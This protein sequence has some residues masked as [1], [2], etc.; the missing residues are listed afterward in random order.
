LRYSLARVGRIEDVVTP[1]YDVISPAEQER[2]YAASPYNIV[3]LELNKAQAGDNDHDNPARRAAAELSRWRAEGV[4]ARD[5]EP[6]FYL[7]ETDYAAQ[8]QRYCRRGFIGV[9][10]AEEFGGMVRRHE[11]TFS[12]VKADRLRLIQECR[13][14]LSPVFGLYDDAAD[15]AIQALA[16]HATGAPE[17]SFD[18]Q[19]GCTH[20][21]WRVSN[22]AALR[23]ATEVLGRSV[24]VVADGHHRYETA[25]L[26]GQQMRARYPEAPPRAP[27]NYVMMYLCNSL[28]PGLTVLPAHRLV[29]APA[30]F[31]LPEFE[32]SAAAFFEVERL[33]QAGGREAFLAALTAR[34]AAGRSAIGLY[35][36]AGEPYR[37]LTLKDGVM[38]R[39]MDGPAGDS[40][41][42]P[43][44]RL[45][46][47]VF[48]RIVL[49]RL[50]GLPGDE[51]EKLIQY[52]SDS[53]QA[54]ETA[55]A[56]GRL[57]FLLN[58]TKV[59]QVQ[60]VAAQ[61]LTMPRKSTYFCPKVMSG[62]A[63]HPLD[64]PPDPGR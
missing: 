1:P 48:G 37:L 29:A 30:G 15:A 60:E 42:G 36:G 11:M 18:D 44:R 24:I 12:R 55:S 61:S 51:D 4:L 38:D 14:N 63:I 34:G 6:S 64:Y 46:V 47:V 50:L 26:Y 59:S 16:A 9:V 43:L 58:P 52:V 13:A 10:R 35:A 31:S 27:F 57:A 25:V 7:C 17:A 45:D 22:P 40:L 19:G 20:R 8:G 53:N 3:R 54:L 21:L 49:Q 56:T 32:R 5:P 23:T 28:A 33:G 39:L 2:Y 62:L 41:A